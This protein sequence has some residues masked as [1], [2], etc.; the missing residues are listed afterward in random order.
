VTG[1]PTAAITSPTKLIGPVKVTFSRVVHGVTT[2]NVAI[3]LTSGG[4]NLAASVTCRD[5]GGALVS[6]STGAVRTVTLDP[7][8]NLVAG[9]RYTIVVGAPS[10]PAITDDGASRV[11]HTTQS[12]RAS[13]VEDDNSVGARYLRTW[14]RKRALAAY[15]DAYSHTD[16]DG[17]AVEFKFRGTGIDWYPILGP[18]MGKAAVFVDGVLKQTVDTYADRITHGTKRSIRGLSDSVHT[19]KI[20]VLGIKRGASNGTTVAVDRWGVV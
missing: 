1:R 11:P 13:L 20:V 17:A 3:R 19:I 4:A 18:G 6:C 16:A 12:F 5:G 2:T 10:T 9:Q 15:G 14:E 8:P 7:A